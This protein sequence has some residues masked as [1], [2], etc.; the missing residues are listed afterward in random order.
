ME[1]KRLKLHIEISDTP[2]V[3]DLLSELIAA[4][5]TQY[6]QKVVILLDEYD[7]PYTDFVYD[8][9]MAEK[10][11]EELRIYYVRIKANDEYIRFKF[12]TGIS[13]FAGFSVFSTLNTPSDISMMAKYAEICGYTA[14]MQHPK[15]KPQQKQKVVNKKLYL[16]T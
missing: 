4:T 16:C 13:K 11:R 6:N 9:D 2:F 3:G 12:I 15:G 5:A 8:P 14:V 1:K 7:K 10:V